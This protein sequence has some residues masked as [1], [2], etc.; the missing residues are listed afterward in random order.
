MG[1]S[2]TLIYSL[3]E[4]IF[5]HFLSLKME[6]ETCSTATPHPPFCP[7]ILWMF[8]QNGN[9]DNPVT[10]KRYGLYSLRVC[11]LIPIS[12]ARALPSF[13]EGCYIFKPAGHM[14]RYD[15]NKGPCGNSQ[16][17][18]V[19]V[20]SKRFIQSAVFVNGYHFLIFCS[21]SEGYGTMWTLPNFFR[22]LMSVFFFLS[23]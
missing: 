9:Q 22:T 13:S 8:I 15:L 19:G 23:F 16:I 10:F 7:I 17:I 12:Q 4:I 3:Y 21:Y 11:D 2:E 5:R 18:A 1:E 6:G 14:T 20:P